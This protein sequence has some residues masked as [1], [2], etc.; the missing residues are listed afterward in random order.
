MEKRAPEAIAARNKIRHEND[1]PEA[2]RT[3]NNQASTGQFYFDHQPVRGVGVIRRIGEAF[4]DPL[5]KKKVPTE[6]VTTNPNLIPVA[7]RRALAPL[8]TQ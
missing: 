8:A 6:L 5:R 1:D 3:F 4:V 7:P 2:L